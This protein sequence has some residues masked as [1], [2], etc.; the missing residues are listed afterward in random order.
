[1]SKIPYIVAF[2]DEHAC[3]H[4]WVG[5]K[6]TSLGRLVKVGFPVPPGFTISTTAYIEFLA[7]LQKKVDAILAT[8]NYEDAAQLEGQ[9]AQI[10]ELIIGAE[11][12]TSL[13][14]VITQ[15]WLQLGDD[16]TRVAVRSSGT[17][18]DLAEASFAGLHDTYLEVSGEAAFMLA[19]KRCWAS[20]WNAR[21][22]HYRHNK[23]FDNATAR[24]A[25]VVQQMVPSTVAGVMFTANPLN[26]RTD[27]FVIN[28]S[29]GLGEAVVSGI[30]TPDEYVV[31]RKTGAVKTSTCGSKEMQIIRNPDGDG[32]LRESVLPGKQTEFSLSNESVSELAALGLRVMNHYDGLPQD[33][34]WAWLDGRLY[35]LQSRPVTGVEFTW[36]EDIND[37]I[38]ARHDDNT[39]WTSAW[40]DDFMTGGVT[41][42]YYSVRVGGEF[43]GAHDHTNRVY[44]FPGLEGRL[45][46]KYRRATAYFNCDIEREWNVLTLPSRL[47]NY[48]YVPYTWDDG[49]RKARFSL[50][51]IVKMLVRLHI[52]EPR[53]GVLHWLSDKPGGIYH[54]INHRIDEAN[55]PTPN[56]LR[57]LSNDELEAQIA[58]T[59]ALADEWVLTLWAGFNFWAVGALGTLAVAS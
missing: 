26:T 39:V 42:L 9:T 52:L 47:R 14:T 7:G 22:V 51:K 4:Q 24:I 57:Q 29:W 3:E 6:A 58:K 12:S 53:T 41:P 37:T 30:V 54:Y 36:D 45:L 40:S 25:V 10:R 56:A 19:V 23:S 2:D 33:I 43:Q 59:R 16:A 38:P 11:L 8:A 34:E 31:D 5:G 28:A 13:A 55:G 20:L 21:A 49:L 46:F 50:Y 48:D 32:T 44:G 1:M 18:E 27:E 17:A 35:I 15:A